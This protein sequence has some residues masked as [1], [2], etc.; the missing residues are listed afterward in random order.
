VV[1]RTEEFELGVF[2][3]LQFTKN[4]AINTDADSNTKT[5][6]F[7]KSL[8]LDSKQFAPDFTVLGPSP[9]S[10]YVVSWDPKPNS[11]GEI[12]LQFET[13]NLLEVKK[14]VESGEGKIVFF[15]PDENSPGKQHLWFRDPV[16]NLINVI[17]LS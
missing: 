16:G 13:D 17:E 1:L 9:Y 15:G 4:V 14:R 12:C 8:G 6:E 2:M 3:K 7:Y 5:S 10:C 11:K